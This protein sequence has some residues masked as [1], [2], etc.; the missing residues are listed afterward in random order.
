MSRNGVTKLLVIAWFSAA[1]PAHVQAGPREKSVTAE[2]RATGENANAMEQARLDALRRAVRE[3]CGEY[4]NAQT[5]AKNYTAI[6]DRVMASAAGYVTE[7]EVLSRR[8]EGG[9][10]ITASNCGNSG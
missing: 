4:I 2:G 3:A 9:T 5:V 1:V 8:V 6:Y 7:S 10:G